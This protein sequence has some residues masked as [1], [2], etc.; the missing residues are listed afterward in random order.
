[1]VLYGLFIVNIFCLFGLLVIIL[2]DENKRKKL[3]E[4][5]RRREMVDLVGG[6]FPG[7]T[8]KRPKSNS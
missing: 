6:G 2:K 1:M 3:R 8:G 5:A 7:R 4:E